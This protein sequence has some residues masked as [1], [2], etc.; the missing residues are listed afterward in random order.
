MVEVLV[1]LF[2][3]S[4]GL[5]G[6]AA[7]QTV[8][9][10]ANYGAHVRSQATAMSYEIMDRMRANRQAALAG[11]YDLVF[12]AIIEAPAS[13]AETDLQDWQTALAATLPNGDGQVETLLADPGNSIPQRVRVTVRWGEVGEETPFEFVTETQL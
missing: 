2:V 13:R 3:L 9:L 8:G 12:G 5:L 6:V 1:A 11:D 10:R 4:V 7:M